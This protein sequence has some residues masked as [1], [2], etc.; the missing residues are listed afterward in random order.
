EV[1]ENPT[2]NEINV[3]VQWDSNYGYSSNRYISYTSD[4]DLVFET[5]DT[6]VAV[7]E[8]TLNDDLVGHVYGTSTSTVRP[9]QISYNNSDDLSRTYNLTI[10]AGERRALMQFVVQHANEGLLLNAIAELEAGDPAML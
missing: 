6:S 10:P 7:G 2:E 8:T 4:G 1:I 3:S 5:D 9:T